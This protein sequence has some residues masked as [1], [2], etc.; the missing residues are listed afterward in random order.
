MNWLSIF[1]RRPVATSLLMLAIA[2][3]GLLAFHFLPMASLPQVDMP[4]LEVSARQPGASPE[5]MATSV[6]M[7]LER[8]MGSIAGINELTSTSS[9]GSTRISL[10][11]D[12]DRNPDGAAR[13]V[14]SAIN[15][16]K[17][18]LPTLP[19]NPTYRKSAPNRILHIA[20]TS[21]IYTQAQLYDLA[22]TVL[23][24]RISQV[25][26]VGAVDVN[27]SALRS[28][29]VEVNP[30]A[31]NE[32][33]ISL[34]QVRAALASA[35][36]NQPKGFIHDES[37]IWQID[38]NDEAKH[39]QNYEDL[40][41]AWHNNAPVRLKDVASVI[42]SVQDVRNAGTLRGKPAVILSVNKQPDANV[43]ATVDAVRALLPRMKPLI[44]AGVEMEV[45][46]DR[47][48]TV[49]KSLHDVGLTLII[50]IALVILV[51]FVFLRNGRATLI[52]S[53]TIPV[54]LMGTLAVIYLCGFSLN[55]LTLMA[56]IIATGFV[57]D[58]AIVVVENISRHI[59]K[60]MPPVQ[61]AMHGI[62][63]VSFTLIAIS[64]ALVAVFIPLLMMG[65]VVGR[66]FREF[67]VTL[68]AA[69]V[70]S[71]IVSLI[72]TPM[73]CS[74][75]LRPREEPKQH[76]LL[77]WLGR[78]L[79][80]PFKGYERS[81]SWVLR[82]GLLM[83]FL[84]LVTIAIN[85]YLLAIVPKG[86]FP[87]QDTGRI[88]GNFQGDQS[89]SFQAMRL[90]IEQLMKIVAQDPDI[91][92]YYEF[93]GGPR[94]GQ[95][96]T[97]SMYATLKPR[98]ERT[99]SAQEIVARLRPKLEK[100]PGAALRLMAEQDFNMGARPGSG[101]YQYTL[102]ADNLAELNS[103][104][105]RLRAALSRLPELTDVSTDFQDKGLQTKLVI[106]RDAA[107][108]LGVTQRQIDVTLNDAFGQRLA[109]TIYEP[110]NQYYVV[111]T[112]A[113]QYTQ[114]PEALEHIYL[115]TSSNAKIPL[116]AI[117][118][119]ENTNSPLA[120]NHQEQFAAATISFNL[121]SK[122]S[123]DQASLAIET[124]FAQLNPTDSMRGTFA[125]LAKAFQKS[126][127]N[128]PWLILTALL[129][130]YIVLGMLY[131][132]TLHPLTILSTVPSAGVGALLA[133]LIFGCQFNLI[134]MIGMILLI[135]LVL[136][137]AIMMI[138]AA[139]WIER[140]QAIPPEQAIRLACLQRFRPI[141]MTTCAAM[142]GA[143]P[144][145][146]GAGDGAEV[147]VPLGISIVGGLIFSQVLT[148]YTTPVIYLYLDRLRLFVSN[149]WQRNQLLSHLGSTRKSST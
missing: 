9:S 129:A 105:P 61:A 81:L 130:V 5:T 37:R 17:A 120:V 50:S 49:R 93:S 1:I 60:G 146:L 147:R 119:W 92:A 82:H 97:G 7:P 13:D 66:I 78:I 40:I 20:L 95:A 21:D 23:G 52:P 111:L 109:T 24:Q 16:A 39:A 31:L 44:P 33:G 91:D 27:G 110:L 59:E 8:A 3:P 136:K 139:L 117:S 98:S 46:V 54:S 29:R 140:E 103:M 107:A 56:L 32:Y 112:L 45:L 34:E 19:S 145:A 143:L 128:Q 15:A 88:Q 85:I 113:P 125:G 69:V 96:N 64:L 118:H 26:G 133:L 67:S 106:D 25:D 94:G 100:V 135:G 63:E 6:A 48:T 84:L 79:E 55:N 99:A 124:A 58:D 148:L 73:L 18:L 75:L 131:E 121:A 83:L 47:S 149:K 28:V 134:A 68:A 144:L 138:D 116:S 104:A 108:R 41:V 35:N 114:G 86:F 38:V 127:K 76:G 80:L 142:L 77:A 141:L 87:D 132:S 4:I 2:L 51:T 126:M 43:V 101:Q 12:I 10:E 22:F 57:V 115:T 14:L 72:A 71:L 36:A 74:R 102:L 62:R 89:I 122:V 53:I 70:I 90:K 65:G 137:N 42:D 11:F 30:N 123:L